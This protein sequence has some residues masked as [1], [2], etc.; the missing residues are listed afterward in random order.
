MKADQSGHESV[1]YLATFISD[2]H[3]EVVQF[4][5][6][7]FLCGFVSLFGIATNVINLV[8]FYK[9]G[10]DSTTNI[11][12]FALAVSDLCC[13][14]IQQLISFY[15][16]PLTD[17]IRL[18]LM[19][20]DVQHMTSGVPHAMF[21]RITCL[22]TVYMTAERCLCVAFPL[23]IKQIIT[24]RRTTAIIG[25]IYSVTLVSAVPIYT[26]NQLG[27]K[28][29]P[30]FN[31][32]LLGIVM[33]SENT[34]GITIVYFTH[35]FSG[36][37]S[38]MV[39]IVLTAILMT[40]LREKSTWR[41]KACAQQD[42][43]GSVSSRDRTTMAMVVL[44]ASVLIVCYTP[45]TLLAVTTVWEPEFS[46]GGRYNNLYYVLWSCAFFMETIN[47][48]ANIFLY[49]KMSSKYRQ[50]FQEMFHR[51]QQKRH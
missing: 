24:T 4:V 25:L 27:W 29:Y 18:P 17:E 3:R 30:E 11:S 41:K 21:S 28:F 20:T 2:Y 13:L 5:N 34:A 19:Y 40:K 43:S 26:V 14:L 47:S 38:F 9:Q 12:F 31:Q 35:A 32:T 23:H 6:Y 39:I 42:S 22:I 44:I 36:L 15:N 45:S 37:L 1:K 33:T 7:V 48:S 16:F 49:L 50:A 10:L 46:V 8:I 51:R